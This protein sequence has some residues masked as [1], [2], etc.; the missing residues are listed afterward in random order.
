VS[1]V[2]WQTDLLDRYSDLAGSAGR[3]GR[4]AVDAGLATLHELQ[5]YSR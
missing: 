1:T 3:S 4:L 2:A 5:S